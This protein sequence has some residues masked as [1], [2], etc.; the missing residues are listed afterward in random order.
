MRSRLPCTA[1]CSNLSFCC[2]PGILLHAKLGQV[3]NYYKAFLPSCHVRYLTKRHPSGGT[4]ERMSIFAE[5]RTFNQPIS[6]IT[7]VVMVLFHIGT[8]AALFMF[9]WKVLLLALILWWA[10]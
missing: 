1:R 4:K 5:D 7:T 2:F 10:A 3:H 8:V 6:P 9:S